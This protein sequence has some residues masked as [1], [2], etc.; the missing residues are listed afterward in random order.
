MDYR[1]GRPPA[2]DYLQPD[3]NSF[4]LVGGGVGRST[5][6]QSGDV[7]AGLSAFVCDVCS[8]AGENHQAGTCGIVVERTLLIKHGRVVMESIQNYQVLWFVL[9]FILLLG[10]ALLDGFDL[11]LAVLL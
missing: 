3:E 8:T 10:Y 4:C 9:I 5:D 6:F 7:Y 2:L 11:G 1:G